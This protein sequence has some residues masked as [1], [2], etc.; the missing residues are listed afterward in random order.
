MIR[1]QRG[2]M[3]NGFGGRK[4]MEHF[5]LGFS[6]ATEQIELVNLYRKKLYGTSG[7]FCIPTC[8]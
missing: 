8:A 3:T 1:V 7:I 5:D 4:I 6:Y 2:G